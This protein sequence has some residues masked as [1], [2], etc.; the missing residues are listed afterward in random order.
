MAEE[1]EREYARIAYEVAVYKE[2]LKLLERE[3]QRVQL[4]AME[5]GKASATCSN[6][7][8]GD[9][10]VPVGGGAYIRAKIEASTTLVPIG[11]NYLVEMNP[12]K[13]VLEIHKRIEATQKATEKLKE[14][15]QKIAEKLNAGNRAM[16]KLQ[17]RL[18][19]DRRVDSNINEDYI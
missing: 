7:K 11:G 13:A 2:Q 8:N 6:L 15:Y 16:Q 19:I 4:T 18:V 1:D 3:M 5:L 10:V 12:D 14:E 17:A 9:S